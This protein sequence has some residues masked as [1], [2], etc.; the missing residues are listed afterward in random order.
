MMSH[1]DVYLG[2]DM[3]LSSAGIA[4]I[5]V[6]KGLPTLLIATRAR[7][8]PKKRHGERLY[9]IASKMRAIS[10]EY[11]PFRQVIREQGFSR[12]AKATQAIF[13]SIGVSDIVFKDYD[14]E[15]YSP[16]AIKSTIAQYGK[17]SKDEVEENVRAILG[18]DEEY[19]FESDDAS[20][21]CA[22]ILTHLIKNK[23]I[24]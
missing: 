9:Q 24:F 17:A 7:T 1:R 16:T 14:I 6:E 10:A 11:G 5:A 21:A 12:F 15:E 2:L 19:V 22:I 18:L 23:L 8:N 3:S 13:K 20:D 4:A